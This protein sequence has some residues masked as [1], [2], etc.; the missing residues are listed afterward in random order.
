[1]FKKYM[2][3]FKQYKR[4]LSD[5]CDIEMEGDNVKKWIVK[6]KNTENLQLT[7]ENTSAF[8]PPKIRITNPHIFH[9]CI[10]KDGNFDYM[11]DKQTWTPGMQVCILVQVEAWLKPLIKGKTSQDPF[12]F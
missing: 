7:Y 4:Q 3:Q 9:P 1:M 11:E 10:D 6:Y 8:E 2:N 12:K 5:V